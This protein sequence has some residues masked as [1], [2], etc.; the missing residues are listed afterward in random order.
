[1]MFWVVARVIMKG[2]RFPIALLANYGRK[3]CHYQHS[4]TSRDSQKHSS[5]QH[6]QTA[7]QSCVVGTTALDLW[8]EA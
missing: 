6:S 3:F 4:S 1:M 7:S 5:N 2:V 8:L